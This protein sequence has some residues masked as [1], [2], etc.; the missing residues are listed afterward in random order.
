[1]DALT[2]G[3]APGY[4]VSPLRGD[5]PTRKPFHTRA[6]RT[7]HC[8]HV[9]SAATPYRASPHF[10]KGIVGQAPR[11]LEKGLSFPFG[12]TGR[13]GSGLHGLDAQFHTR[14]ARLPEHLFHIVHG[15]KKNP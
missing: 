8:V 9:A 1:M 6:E 5:R 12:L 11:P 2:R 14:P 3:Y 7:P 15:A 4:D 13:P 10:L